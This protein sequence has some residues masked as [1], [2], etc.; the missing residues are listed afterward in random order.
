MSAGRIEIVTSVLS[1]SGAMELC[2][3]KG[4]EMKCKLSNAFMV[5]VQTILDFDLLFNYIIFETHQR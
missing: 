4:V 2:D 5:P 3:F 1:D